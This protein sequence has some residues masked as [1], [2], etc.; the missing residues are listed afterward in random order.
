LLIDQPVEHS[1]DAEHS[2]ARRRERSLDPAADRTHGLRAERTNAV[3]GR[4]NPNGAGAPSEPTAGGRNEPNGRRSELTLL[5]VRADRSHDVGLNPC[6]CDIAKVALQGFQP[7]EAKPREP[8]APRS[9]RLR[10]I[11]PYMRAVVERSRRMHPKTVGSAGH[12]PNEPT[13]GCAERMVMPLRRGQYPT[14]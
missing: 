7:T 3:R 5:H 9:W 10:P 11:V 4:S 1:I 6:P 12:V 14:P 13:A 8:T 2:I